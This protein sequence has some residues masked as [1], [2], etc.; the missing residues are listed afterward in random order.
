MST[1]E[2]RRV[3]SRAW[4]K[5]LPLDHQK[6]HLLVASEPAMLAAVQA[7]GLADRGL[8]GEARAWNAKAVRRVIGTHRYGEGQR[9]MAGLTDARKLIALQHLARP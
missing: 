5:P 6:R 2:V 9:V 7:V 1:I 4:D 8:D 3:V